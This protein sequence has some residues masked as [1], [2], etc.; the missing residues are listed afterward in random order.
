MRKAR[1][2]GA[3][4][5]RSGDPGSAPVSAPTTADAARTTL[6]GY[7]PATGEPALPGLA[8]ARPPA[9]TAVQVPGPFDDRFTLEALRFDGTTA[10][11]AVSITS[12]VSDL[13][14]LQV[15]AGFYDAAGTLIGTA[16]ADQHEDTTN[17][18]G[19]G[20]HAPQQRH[21]VSVPVPAELTGRAVSAALG[22]TV[23]VNE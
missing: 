14:D 19:E 5:A 21:P 17:V 1:L 20:D 2:A 18:A 23:L 16:R 6:P 10:S 11:A 7:T 4:V 13:L 3:G 22:V 8:T 9:G 12:D 15:L